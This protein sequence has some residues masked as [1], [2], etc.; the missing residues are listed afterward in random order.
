MGV[1]VLQGWGMTET[2]PMCCL[3]I[4][5]R[6]IAADEE[7]DWRAKSGRP[8]PGMQVRI[9]NAENAPLPNDGETIGDLQ[10][11]GPWVT[12]S[13]H[14]NPASDSFSADGWLRTGDVGTIDPQGYVQITDRTKD[15]IK[16]GGE[17]VSSVDLENK[18]AGCPGVIEVGVIGIPDPRWEERPLVFLVCDT[19]QPVVSPQT[20][21][22]YL[23]PLIA[24]F[25]LP[26]NFAF[27]TA[28]PKTSVG[29]IDKVALRQLFASGK[30]DVV[31]AR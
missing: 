30:V 10:L 5:P 23:A 20:I 6:S 22:D 29:K 24:R 21:R 8:V 9:V 1:P 2:S 11:R 3:S 17:W 16:S 27:V 31:K 28:I 25:A 15:V 14:N 7:A 18:I 12:G 13:Y 4:P 26:E 19:Q